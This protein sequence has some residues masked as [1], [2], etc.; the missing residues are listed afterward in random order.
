MTPKIHVSVFFADGN[1]FLERPSAT[2]KRRSRTSR[3]SGILKTSFDRN[4][5]TALRD[6]LPL[7]KPDWRTGQKPELFDDRAADFA[8]HRCARLVVT[9]DGSALR[10]EGI[11]V[12]VSG[13]SKWRSARTTRLC[14]FPNEG[15]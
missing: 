10:R 7:F 8:E 3:L 11:N 9:A 14:H 13:A 4:A 1:T 2:L 6:P 12:K 5:Y 15:C